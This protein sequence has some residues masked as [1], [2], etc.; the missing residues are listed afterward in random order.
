M[1]RHFT[2][3]ICLLLTLGLFSLPT[4]ASTLTV[5][6]QYTTIQ[7]AINAS[8]NGD[9]V[10]IA[11]GTYTGP[12][13]V[14][15]DFGGKNITVTSQ[16]GA[17]RTII[18]CQ[19]SSSASH[20]GFYLHSGETSAIIS[21]LT[22][23]NGYEIGN[24]QGGG[25]NV[26][27][28]GITIQG[29]VLKN[30]TSGYGGG[31]WEGNYNSTFAVINCVFVGNKAI[32]N[33]NGLQFGYGGG[34]YNDTS[35]G[36]IRVINCT[37]TGN[38]ATGGGGGMYNSSG[39]GSTILDTNDLL[40]G[41]SGGELATSGSGD[42]ISFCDIQGGYTG[43]GNVTGN[44]NADPKIAN[45]PA[46]LHLQPGSPCLNAGTAS[47]APATTI[48]G[49]TRPNPPSIGAY[50]ALSG[51]AAASVTLSSSL[52]PS[53]SGQKVTFNAN[54]NAAGTA[55]TGNITYS[56]DGVAAASVALSGKS[57]AYSLSTLAS[58]THTVMASYSGDAVYAPVSSSAL[59]QT[60][61]SATTTTTLTSSLNP[62]SVN[63]VLTFTAT[64]TG[65]NPS[66][67]IT[68]TDTT[69]GL[70]LG[71]GSF[72]GG[73]PIAFT[74]NNL[75]GGTHKITV[76]YGG[77]SGNSPSVSPALT[78]TVKP[79]A[80][81]TTVSSRVNPSITGQSNTLTV[82]VSGGGSFVVV[83]TGTVT[84]TI[85]G[86][87]QPPITLSNGYYAAFD[88]SSLATGSH[89]I[90]A[91]YSGDASYIASTSAVLTQVV[92]IHASPQYVSPS[93][94]D[95]NPGTQAAPKLTIQAA[96]T[97]ALSGDT[98]IIEDGTYTGPGNVDLRFGGK[99]LTVTSQ[100]GPATTIID[101]GGSINADHSGF[102]LSTNYG[103]N[104]GSD[105]G[106]ICGLTIQHAVVGGNFPGSS[107]YPGGA[108]L[109]YV[110]LTVQN[111]I[112]K[113]NTA[114][115]GGGIEIELQSGTASV[116][117]CVFTGNT[118]GSGGGL[119]LSADGAGT[120]SVVNCTVTGNTA[121]GT[122]MALV[123]GGIAAYA[124]PYPPSSPAI[125]LTN[126]IIYGDT[127]GEVANNGQS[128]SNPYT[129]YCDIQG[130]YAGT[131][132]INADPLF[133]NS[134]SDLHL[135][136]ASPCLSAGTAAGAP[137][138]TIDGSTRLTPPS[139]GAYEANAVGTSA[140]S[141]ALTS[142]VNPSLPGQSVTFTAAVS[143]A[144]LVP[145]GTLIFTVDGTAQPAAALSAGKA[146]YTTSTLISGSHTLTALYS[147]DALYAAGHSYPLSQIVNTLATSTVTVLASGLN[148][149]TYG[150]SVALTATVTGKNPVGTVTFT[151]TAS[152]NVLG[153]IN[154][155]AGSATATFITP[156][157]TVGSHQII[158]LYSGDR[159]NSPSVSSSLTQLVNIASTTLTLTSSLNP[160]VAGQYVFFA[161]HIA[162]IGGGATSGTV[163]FT[164]DGVIVTPMSTNDGGLPGLN[165]YNLTA[166]TH[167]VSATYSG[168]TN[169]TVC[170]SPVLT[171]VVRTHV[172]PQYVSP[173]GNDSNLGTQTSPKLTIQA[174]INSTLNGDTVI[175]EDG[176]YTG[177]GNVD[178][179]L[180]GRSLMV[181]SQNGAATT[182]IDCG[183]NS[184]AF[185]RAF[186]FYSGETGI[187]I[188]GFTIQNGYETNSG[189][190]IVV[191]SA[192]VSIQNCLIKNNVASEGGGIYTDTYNGTTVSITNCQFVG[193]SAVYG[194]AIICF[195]YSAGT[196]LIQNCLIAGNNA[197]NFG[198]GIYNDCTNT[199]GTITIAN[200][201]LTA[202]TAPTG[203]G[204]ANYSGTGAGVIT[205]TNDILY[206]DTGYE[207]FSD[208]NSA[209]GA[210]A[211]FCDIQGG[212]SGT[213]NINAD[214]LFVNSTSDLH[215]M[216]GSP[217][218]SAG[219]PS[220]APT[221]TIDGRTRP[222]PPSIGAYEVYLATTFVGV[223]NVSG[224]AGQTV[225]LSAG[226]NPG[227][228]GLPGATL[229]FSVDGTAVGTAVTGDNST[230]SGPARLSY[231]IPVGFIPGSH[232]ITATFSGDATDLS[233]SGTGT[234]TVSAMPAVLPIQINAGG[235]AAGSFAADTDYS[236]SSHTFATT[237]AISTT[238]VTNP[239]PQA[240]YQ[241]ERYGNFTYTLP[242]L[243][244]GASYTLRL[245]FA[246]NYWTAAGKRLFNVAVNGASALANFDIFAAA[247]GANKAVAETFL[248]KADSSG[249]VTV[250]FTSIK[251]NA[252]LS[253]LELAAAPAAQTSVAQI[254]SGG[255]A[256]G[257]FAA[258]TDFSGSSHTFATTAAIS[259][260]GV[261]NPA[262]QAVYQTE[263]YGSFTYTL[264]NLT[265]GASYTLCL[266]FAENY[267][268]A[269]NKR[270]FN[271]AVNGTSVLANFDIFAA[272]GGANKAV[273][274]TYLVTADS[275]GKVTVVF[276]SVKD[277]AKLS[278]LELL[279]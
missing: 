63:Q 65:S 220:G 224:V 198:G 100:N 169:T 237:A 187:V 160:S 227:T 132:N 209:N 165:T 197:T 84:F 276:T 102:S 182:I 14:D 255:S 211:T 85:D 7:A 162:G 37:F 82:N 246:E 79:V 155:T 127:G 264:P 119:F 201:T 49:R 18:D 142:S 171:Q 226:L 1:F 114:G 256:A 61:M 10:L 180:G 103:L 189:G 232:T 137:T 188:R 228:K 166:G 69:T 66:G 222:N 101:C 215:L 2:A 83:P 59:T 111:C 31:I 214:P 30:N 241:T 173:S 21:G 146:S 277:N 68:L 6:A 91:S 247:G 107:N 175:V 56:I 244:P 104:L 157:L 95:S 156:Q 192:N 243:T 181:S 136:P 124:Y 253:G 147:G 151:D 33:V 25:I 191:S 86:A 262:P 38:S 121:T 54:L 51:T 223:A 190:G 120:I 16:N 230:S 62:S 72:S 50:E 184:N 48:D 74:V 129:S 278:G 257:S 213:G 67:A 123:G 238:G 159:I 40:Y 88:A 97:T 258:D 23:Q 208:P 217:C 118:A 178:L 70:V 90:T 99:I 172:S 179:D 170:T 274:E 163:T 28:S 141:V 92:N 185:H 251:D 204:M 207:I 240:V 154:L 174:A 125:I 235:S 78:Q 4:S 11:D 134:A 261:T 250:V 252:K 150:Q 193:N 34:L 212:F 176:T 22:I 36:T 138:T 73:G 200:C 161:A 27:T 152:N 266:H 26:I 75:G 272:A 60:V 203:G 229:Q 77:D 94:S 46:D 234:L 145:T 76:S 271:V 55:P 148:P 115:Q 117:N 41:D 231:I 218:L 143:G 233:A 35:V 43:S 126:D 139:I 195:G 144:S 270:L 267:W 265:P 196:T 9:T 221:T 15:L 130:G 42:T 245:H 105:G 106:T 269:A 122:G 17:T 164:L 236:G 32:S 206:A 113:N 57:A 186:S 260:T 248:V 242:N 249:K 29:C 112:I 259:T 133:V 268:T 135:L 131:R 45:P 205:L 110:G 24:N 158:A 71:T 219:T 44:I 199:N 81:T 202:N 12:G 183:G 140:D 168:D 89:T 273:V 153:I 58:G 279:H 80:T 263:R 177:P 13:D 216:T 5:P 53:T 194:G 8:V 108:I 19:G 87:A 167:T 225:T 275:S 109:S 20:R 39:S 149:S 93:G 254:N 98:V 47:G 3:L 116:I 96:M 239:A 128:A 64:V 52:N 210:F